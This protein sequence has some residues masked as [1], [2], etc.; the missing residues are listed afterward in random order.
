MTTAKIERANDPCGYV[1]L[2]FYGAGASSL[3]EGWE[4]I[5]CEKLHKAWPKINEYEISIKNS[6]RLIAN[7]QKQLKGSKKWY[8]FWYT[9]PERELCSKI[10]EERTRIK[11]YTAEVDKL[12]DNLFESTFALQRKAEKY[13]DDL[14]FVLTESSRSGRYGSVITEVWTKN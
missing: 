1:H 8:R 4:Q 6:E 5:R 13:L 14:G 12:E 3:E 11:A 2:Y 9:K 10:E 7:F